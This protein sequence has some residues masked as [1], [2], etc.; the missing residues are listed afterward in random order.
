V[1]WHDVFPE[2]ERPQDLSGSLE[3][4]RKQNFPQARR[5]EVQV[6]EGAHVAPEVDALTFLQTGL[7]LLD[8]LDGSALLSTGAIR[9]RK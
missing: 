2:S 8:Q 5:V 1:R 9:R 6:L 7:T 3:E 4:Y